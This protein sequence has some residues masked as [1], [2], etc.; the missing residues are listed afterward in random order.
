MARA[1]WGNRSKQ[2]RGP[3][4]SKGCDGYFMKTTPAQRKQLD[5]A[6]LTDMVKLEQAGVHPTASILSTRL[7]PAGWG[8]HLGLSG[9]SFLG[10]INRQLE[11]LK[12]EGWVSDRIYPKVTGS[13][14]RTWGLTVAGLAQF[15]LSR[16]GQPPPTQPPPSNGARQTHNP[17]HSRSPGGGGQS[18]AQ[19]S[20]TRR[21][22]PDPRPEVPRSVYEAAVLLGVN[23]LAGTAEINEAYRRWA[24]SLHPDRNPSP[25]DSA[26]QLKR[27]NGAR[28]LLLDF[29]G[30]RQR[31]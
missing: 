21:R 8:R 29:S 27:I 6:L 25:Q 5:G 14:A 16:G 24:K 4:F 18:S 26:E 30:T 7:W 23:P 28:D 3:Q 12:I 19:W 10:L 13:R 9:G 1:F 22:N 20:G 2:T 17:G 15:G 31:R 11:S